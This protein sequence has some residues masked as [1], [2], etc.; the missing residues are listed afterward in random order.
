M[1]FGK[2]EDLWGNEEKFRIEVIESIMP[3]S[4]V[5]LDIGP[6]MVK[7]N[8]KNCLLMTLDLKGPY[9]SV[10]GTAESLP[11]KGGLFDLVISTE[12]I[13][14][15]RHPKRML[16]EVRRVMKNDGK[17]LMSTPNVVTLANRIAFFF[18][19]RFP[20]D[21]TLHDDHDVGHLHFW[22]RKYLLEVLNKNGFKVLQSWHKFLQIS[23]KRYFTGSLTEKIFKNFCEQN[24]YLCQKS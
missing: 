8:T 6:G 3:E 9:S 23:R 19:G 5:I 20:P 1:K 17:W 22:D 15:V 16:D 12:V 21:R 24:I 14:H 11:F 7:Y 18:L 13:E 4:G 10:H 2:L